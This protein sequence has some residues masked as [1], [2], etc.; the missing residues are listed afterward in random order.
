MF[1]ADLPRSGPIGRSAQELGT[2]EIR[3]AALALA[4]GGLLL[5][6]R[7]LVE[8]IAPPNPLRERDRTDQDEIEQRE[9]ALGLYRP[10]VGRNRHP[11]LEEPPPDRGLRAFHNY[12]SVVGS[13]AFGA[14]R[15]RRGGWAAVCPGCKRGAHQG[16][17][18]DD[19]VG[20]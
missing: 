11:S 2:L 6:E 5:P 17:G 13:H 12:D 7:V 15:P 1:T 16:T 9:H 20:G 18:T 8:R 3:P 4:P 19:G 14:M 10:K